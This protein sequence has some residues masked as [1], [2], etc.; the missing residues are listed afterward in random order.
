MPDGTYYPDFITTPDKRPIEFLRNFDRVRAKPWEDCSFLDLGCSEGTTTLGLSQM[1]ST[2]Y[3][4]E[5]RADGIDRANVLKDI[6]DFRKTHFSVDNVNNESAFREVDGIFNA[7]ILYHLEDPVEM[8]ERCC[9]YAKSFV[10]VDTGHAPKSEEERR[11]SKFSPYFGREFTIEYQGL[12]LKA[13]DFAEPGDTR[14]KVDGM[15]RG[16]R[17][18][19]GNSNSVW[20]AHESLIELMEKLGFPYHET[21]KY[22]PIIPRLRTCFFR[23]RPAASATSLKLSQP[24]PPAESVD[25]AIRR[26]DA[27]D[28][29]FLAQ[30]DSEI[31]LVGRD[32]LMTQVREKLVEKGIKI[33]NDIIVP[34]VQ[35]DV[36]PTGVLNKLLTNK[37]GIIVVAAPN[38]GKT[39]HPLVKMDRFELAITSLALLLCPNTD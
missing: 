23:E 16:P 28:L 35:G 11:E 30:T 17:S 20:L 8:I 9:K 25:T 10:Y 19:I 7:G 5:G 29:E 13:V 6:V 21:I 14:E 1:G 3:G 12:K 26:T 24:L 15:R 18:G 2:V 22:V 32:P 37:A 39:I 31:T 27:R 36:I 38:P 4:V 33:D 34:G